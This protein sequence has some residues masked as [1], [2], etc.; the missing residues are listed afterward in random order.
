MDHRAFRHMLAQ[1]DHRLHLGAGIAQ[2]QRHAI[3]I[4]IGRQHHRLA[5]GPTP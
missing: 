2:I 3:G 4:V 1:I 5:P